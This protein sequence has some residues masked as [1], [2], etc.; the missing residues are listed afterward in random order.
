MWII[1]R[2]GPQSE[3]HSRLGI[4]NKRRT[5]RFFAP[6]P[7]NQQVL[8]PHFESLEPVGD[9]LQLAEYVTAASFVSKQLRIGLGGP[10]DYEWRERRPSVDQVERECLMSV[11]VS[12]KAHQKSLST[13][14]LR[15]GRTAARHARQRAGQ[16]QRE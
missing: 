4:P 11:A 6:K 13:I 16:K 3:V 12:K 2:G 7:A 5:A 1:A 9:A 8:E 14:P 15:A 10:A